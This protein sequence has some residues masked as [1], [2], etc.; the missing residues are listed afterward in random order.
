M[1]SLADLTSIERGLKWN[2]IGI[3]SAR[4][5]PKVADIW[6]SVLVGSSFRSRVTRTGGLTKGRRLHGRNMDG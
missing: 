6:G 5:S 2:L 4:S 1:L 3:R